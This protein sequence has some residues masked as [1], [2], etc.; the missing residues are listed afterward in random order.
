MFEAFS[1]GYYFGRLYVEPTAGDHAVMQQGQHEQVNRQVYATGEGVERLDAPLV[2]KLDTTHFPVLGE[3][4]V[5]EHTLQVPEQLLEDTDVSQPPEL[6]EVFLAKRDR[7][8]QL[9][10]W[11]SGWQ[12]AVGT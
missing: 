9:L 11:T 2:M 5:P 12:P 4:D 8:E 3:E 1:T 10:R 7:A 6:T